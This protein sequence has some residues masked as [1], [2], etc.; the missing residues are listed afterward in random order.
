MRKKSKAV[1]S[2]LCSGIAGIVCFAT[3]VDANTVRQE[4]A[5]YVSPPAFFVPAI[6]DPADMPEVP[7]DIDENVTTGLFFHLLDT[8]TS[9]TRFLSTIAENFDKNAVTPRS[10]LDELMKLL[11]AY[12][13]MDGD[14]TP[15]PT[16]A[17]IVRPS[18]MDFEPIQKEL[19]DAVGWIRIDG[20]TVNYPI[21]YGT[22]NEFYLKHL[23]DGNKNVRGSIFIDYRN[24]PDFSQPN[25]L[26][27]GHRMKSGAMFGILRNYSS[28]SFYGKHP[29]VSIFTPEGDY[30]VVLFAGYALDQMREIPP[31]GFNDAEDLGKYVQDAKRRSI[32]KSDVEVSFDDRLVSLCTCDYSVKN[33]RLVIVG[34]L[35]E[36]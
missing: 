29:T 11:E 34:K 22:D 1:I 30:E 12:V 19:P 26:V 16:P 28:Q 9:L 17:K 32:F 36:K 14:S 4:E 2:L 13:S 7:E 21:M 33:G 6:L 5:Y 31:M 35:T 24:A 10:I 23:P 3:E 8:L 15:V 27:Y 25:T 20:T 18:A